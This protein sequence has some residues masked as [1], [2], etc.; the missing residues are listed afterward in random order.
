MLLQS[1]VLCCPSPPTSRIHSF[2]SNWRRTASSKF[3]DTQVSS[4]STE[5]LVF[6][7]CVLSRLRCNG[8]SLLL[9]SYL[10]RIGRIKILHAA[11]AVIRPGTLFIS[12]CNVQQR[13]FCTARSLVTHVHVYDL[14]SRPWKI[15]LAPVAPWSSA[16]PPSLEKGRVTSNNSH[17]SL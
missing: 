10:S 1:T 7:R 16:K 2:F 8:H 15:Y 17:K 12:S 11:P 14:W 5:K 3:F 13:T 6:A 4:A 9:N